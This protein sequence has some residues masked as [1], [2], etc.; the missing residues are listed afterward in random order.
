MTDQVQPLPW[1]PPTNF[2]SMFFLSLQKASYPGL[3]IDS[4]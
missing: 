1:S 3:L 4:Q 2:L